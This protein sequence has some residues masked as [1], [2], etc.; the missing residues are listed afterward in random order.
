MGRAFKV[1]I[2]GIKEL[3]EVLKKINQYDTQTQDK[4]RTAVRTSTQNIMTGAKR[5]VRVLTGNM[6][7]SI[8]MTYDAKKNIGIVHAKAPH[9]HLVE[10]GHKGGIET[11]T[12]HKALHGGR[13][14]GFANKVDI[15]NV[16][17]HPFLRPAFED[18][19]PNLI[20]S[21]KEAVEKT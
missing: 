10:L 19:R 4:L 9:A 11:H 20:K 2:G 21:V 15:P 16:A 17:P 14:V 1:N 13:L 8:S 18:E 12:K 3:K 7:K 5:R 6:I